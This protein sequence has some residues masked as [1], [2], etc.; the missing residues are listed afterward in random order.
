[1]KSAVNDISY[2]A[3][4][5]CATALAAFGMAAPSSQIIAWSVIAFILALRYRTKDGMFVR[6]AWPVLMMA[7][8]GYALPIVFVHP[9]AIETLEY[10]PPAILVTSAVAIAASF[11]RLLAHRGQ[12]D[13]GEA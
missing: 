4:I 12:V 10:L 11:V 9:N 6:I 5:S 8:A 3:W 2:A 1:M 7:C 13:K